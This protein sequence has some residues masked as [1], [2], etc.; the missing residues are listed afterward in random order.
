MHLQTLCSTTDGESR[1]GAFA[2]LS[3]LTGLV[4]KMS[5]LLEEKLVAE[6]GDGLR[7]VL[8]AVSEQ[9]NRGGRQ[10]GCDDPRTGEGGAVLQ[11]YSSSTTGRHLEQQRVSC[12]QFRG[13][14]TELELG[15]K[16]KQNEN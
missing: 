5:T 14:K 6:V 11:S 12:G 9:R 8:G 16:T 2:R 7:A 3:D 15:N 4:N 1:A 13:R 10:G